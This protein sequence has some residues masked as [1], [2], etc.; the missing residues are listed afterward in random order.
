MTEMRYRTVGSSGLMV[1]GGKGGDMYL[2]SR[3]NLKAPK[4]ITMDGTPTYHPELHN[5]AYMEN[6]SGQLVYVWPEA[7]P[8]CRPAVVL[9]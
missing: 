8:S 7:E 2:L 5:F 9:P 1:S 4:T 6:A 3:D